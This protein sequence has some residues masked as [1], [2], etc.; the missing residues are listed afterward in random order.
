MDKLGRLAWNRT[1][2]KL[3]DWTVYRKS[4]SSKW[5]QNISK[6]IKIEKSWKYFEVRAYALKNKE[7]DLVFAYVKLGKI[8]GKNKI[9]VIDNHKLIQKILKLMN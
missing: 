1:C 5:Y 7:K 8:K 2:V 6:Y 9:F 4:K 3:I